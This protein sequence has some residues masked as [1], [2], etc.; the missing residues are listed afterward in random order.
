MTTK[1]EERYIQQGTEFIDILN[2]INYH[3]KK[4]KI[5]NILISGPPGIGKTFMCEKIA[6][7]LG[8]GYSDITGHPGLTR[9][10][11][12]GVPELIN[13]NSSWRNGAIPQAIEK[14]NKNELHVFGIHEYNVMRTEVHPS[15]NSYMDYQGKF[16]L[17]TNANVEFKVNDG[18]TVVNLA[19]INEDISGVMEIQESAKTRWHLKV[20]LRY[21]RLNIEKKIL[22]MKT[23]IRP[24]YAEIICKFGNELRIAA[25]KNKLE[26]AVSP[27]ELISFCKILR[28]PGITTEKGFEYTIM[29]KL[30][31]DKE[32]VNLIKDLAK[33]K[34]LFIDL[35]FVSFEDEV[36]QKS[37]KSKPNQKI[38]F[39]EIKSMN[40]Q[41]QALIVEEGKEYKVTE[42]PKLI[43]INGEIYTVLEKG[44]WCPK[45]RWVAKI[46]TD[47]N[48]LELYLKKT[49]GVKEIA[50]TGVRFIT[51]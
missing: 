24:E 51:E 50:R 34:D 48:K 20:N 11:L 40:K 37:E 3:F 30:V 45:D 42:L 23:D 13:G 39:I 8:C 4:E 21:P 25:D 26:R 31:S 38:G 9:E 49:G 47:E 1:K 5:I 33:G 27:R 14:A 29:N 15:L 19:T 22:I 41:G 32:E 17:T 35:K 44:A 7:E 12:E 36:E 46:L 28:V 16:C 43:E 18:C 10:D 2:Y 6:E